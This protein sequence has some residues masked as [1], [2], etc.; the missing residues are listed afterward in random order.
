MQIYT[1]KELAKICRVD[2]YTVRRWIKDGVVK[3]GKIG[4]GPFRIAQT[5][6]DKI[7]LLIKEGVINE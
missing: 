6:L 4:N 1:V 2:D 3:A 7:I 5:E